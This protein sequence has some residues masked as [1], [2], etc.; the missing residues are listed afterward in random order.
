MLITHNHDWLPQVRHCTHAPV[1][2]CLPLVLP[3]CS[4]DGEE[5]GTLI[6]PEHFSQ[7]SLHIH[8]EMIDAS[9]LKH[10]HDYV[11]EKDV[12]IITDTKE[13]FREQDEMEDMAADNKV[14]LFSP[15]EEALQVWKHHGIN[16]RSPLHDLM[17]TPIPS[18][19]NLLPFTQLLPYI[20]MYSQCGIRLQELIQ[21]N[22][23]QKET[24]HLL[25]LSKYS[26]MS[27]QHGSQ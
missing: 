2:H 11:P 15:K 18:H 20:Q 3:E 12:S 24:Y 13:L 19:Q 7:E 25:C 6:N 10:I 27:E 21:Q 4:N 5:S 8:D 23:Q 17:Q 22:L 9:P 16:L 14:T 1:C 26:S